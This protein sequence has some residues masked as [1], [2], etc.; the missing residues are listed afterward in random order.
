MKYSMKFGMCLDN[1]SEEFV[2]RKASLEDLV[3]MTAKLGYQGIEFTPAQMLPSYPEI[4][5]RDTR[6]VRELL[7]KHYLEPFCWNIYLDTGTITG[8]EL[9]EN[10]MHKAVMQ[11]L[12]YAKKAGFRV[13]KTSS[14]ITTK[15]F[16]KL[17]PLCR[18]LDMKLAVEIDMTDTKGS[19]ADI[20]ELLQMIRCEG[21]GQIGVMSDLEALSQC[22]VEIA[23]LPAI[24]FGI[25]IR[26]EA[27]ANHENFIKNAVWAGYSGYLICR[28]VNK[29]SRRARTQA[30]EF[31]K[32]CNSL[33]DHNKNEIES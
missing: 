17:I 26:P 9:T 29:V 14:S 21:E 32:S 2:K 20:G 8:R 3:K 6:Q 13:I 27:I 7:S 25:Y 31:I 10:E 19:E 24:S 22:P 23:D 30:E 16:Q 1:F 18:D 28:N 15:V 5:D 33:L 4:S 12:I 11:N